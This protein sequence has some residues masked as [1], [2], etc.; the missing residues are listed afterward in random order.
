[1]SKFVGL[2]DLGRGDGRG[3]AREPKKAQKMLQKL[4]I[5]GEVNLEATNIAILRTFSNQESLKL[6]LEVSSSRK[7]V[8]MGFFDGRIQ[9]KYFG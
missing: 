3:T 4:V 5:R 9:S 6:L 1:M 2:S 8:I 7:D